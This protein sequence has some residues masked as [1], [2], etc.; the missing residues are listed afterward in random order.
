MGVDAG[1]WGAAGLGGCGSSRGLRETSQGPAECEGRERPGETPR[2]GGAPCTR[3]VGERVRLG[4]V[5]ALP[6]QQAAPTGS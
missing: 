1:E 3:R 5:P 6:G 4:V 2:A